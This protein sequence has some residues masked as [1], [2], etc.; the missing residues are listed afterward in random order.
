MRKGSRLNELWKWKLEGLVHLL[1]SQA[2]PDVVFQATCGFSH[3]VIDDLASELANKA[4]ASADWKSFQIP[5]FMP[6]HA[7]LA[8]AAAAVSLILRCQPRKIAFHSN[9]YV[10]SIRWSLLE[11]KIPSIRTKMA[12]SSPDRKRNLKCSAERE[13]PSGR[14]PKPSFGRAAGQPT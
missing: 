5:N 13:F 8:A 3:D 10:P 1:A 9:C 4:L 14:D 7:N 6:S 2:P 11:L 12:F